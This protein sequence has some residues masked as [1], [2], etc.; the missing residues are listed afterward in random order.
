MTRELGANREAINER[1]SA[2]FE[3]KPTFKDRFHGDGWWI[4]SDGH[5][6][7]MLPDI[8]GKAEKLRPRDWDTDEAANAMLLDQ[9]PE[10]THI[11]LKSGLRKLTVIG[12]PI[13]P[14][15]QTQINHREWTEHE[16][17]KTCVV[18]AFLA[19]AKL[20]AVDAII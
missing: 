11:R 12:V 16:D 13:R 7:W 20:E 1:I 18:L 4:L 8:D 10:D 9:L 3:P 17:R 5:A 14:D 19:Y 2:W 6:W 15:P